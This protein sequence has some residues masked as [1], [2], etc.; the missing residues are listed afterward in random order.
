MAELPI[1]WPGATSVKT[2]M[3]RYV[4]TV[5]IEFSSNLIK[6]EYRIYHSNTYMHA[7]YVEGLVEL[8]CV[9]NP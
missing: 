7:H 3:V 8:V 2:N 4:K 9:A 6:T 5:G 1:R